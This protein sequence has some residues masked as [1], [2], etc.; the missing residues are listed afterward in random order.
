[1][2]ALIVVGIL[3]KNVVEAI[4][5]L[6]ENCN[7]RDWYGRCKLLGDTWTDD[8]TW[9]YKCTTADSSP[10]IISG[11]QAEVGNKSKFIPINSNQTV[12]GFWYSCE[13]DEIHI[14]YSREPRCT[15]NSTI[16]KHVGETFR[17]GT[18]EWLCLET[19]KWVTGCYY[20]NETN[21][22]VL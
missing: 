13:M 6:P 18:F 19:G 9:S 1:M 21:N 20:Q 3:L 22:S 14:K 10:A 16:H 4:E 2:T 12:D 5:V 15:I 7:C 8:N 17:D 11:C